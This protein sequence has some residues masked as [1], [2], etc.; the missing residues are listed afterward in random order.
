MESSGLRAI[1]YRISDAVC[2]PPG[3]TEHLHSEQLVRLPEVLWVYRPNVPVEVS[4][5]P[6]AGA[7]HVTFGMF[8]AFPKI[9]GPCVAAW[10]E[11]LRRLPGSRLVLLAG[12]SPQAD[13]RLAAAF[14]ARGMGPERVT[15]VG[16]Q[17]RADYFRLYH[18]VDLT[19]DTFP[20][21]GCNTSCD[22][23]WMGA[24]VVTLLGRT[25][26]SRMGASPVA[27]L[28]LHEWM[29]ETLE[30]YVETAVRF[31]G[32][33]ARLAALRATLRDRMERTTLM[34]PE[35]FTRQLEDAYR[36]MWRQW[37]VRAADEAPA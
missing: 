26:M 33:V 36:W 32:D 15:L 23:L 7:G 17:S 2:D 10:S 9:T 19:L 4:P 18:R 22:S 28:G 12:V 30:D 14:A 25:C 8:N 13:A 29:V 21:A 5:L 20:Y 35:R 37:C 24:P 16:R 1:D 31:G 6:A 11:I 34:N 3:M 27:H